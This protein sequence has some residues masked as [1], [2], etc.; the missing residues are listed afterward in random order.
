MS[1]EY[2]IFLQALSLGHT[3]IE[4]VTSFQRRE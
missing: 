2:C 4:P 3:Y 1:D